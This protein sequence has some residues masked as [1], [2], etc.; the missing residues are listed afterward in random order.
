MFRMLLRKFRFLPVLMRNLGLAP[1]GSKPEDQPLLGELS[2]NLKT[3]ASLMGSSPDIIVRRFKTGLP[4]QVDAATIYIDGLADKAAINENILRPLVFEARLTGGDEELA[5]EDPVELIKGRILTL[6]DIQRIDSLGEVVDAVFAG[7]TALLVEGVCAALILSTKGWQIR[8]IDEPKTE[9]VV[10]GPRECFIENLRTNT[11]LLRRRIRDPKLTYETVRVGK[12]TKT[13][14]CVAYLKGVTN[15]RL[16][17]EIKRRLNRI[18]T[19][20]VLESGYVEQYIEDAPLSPFATIAN[21]ERPD[22]VAAK[23]LEGRAAI[24]VDGS[25]IVLTVP[26]LFV[27]SFQAPDDYYSRPYFAT[28][29]RWIRYAAFALSVLSPAVYVAL[30]AFHQEL[31]PTPLLI[32]VA[33]AREGAPFPAV[34]EA[35]G[36]GVAFEILREAGLRI[37][38][39]FGQAVSIVGALVIGEATVRA[40]LIGAPVVIV[41][42]LT[43]IC[44]FVVP[45]QQD[46]GTIIRVS[47]T[48]LAGL[49]G[50][51]GIMLGLLAILIHLASLRSFGVPYLSPIAPLKPQDLK[52]VVVRAPWWAMH[53]RPTYMGQTDPER[54]EFRLMPAPPEEGRHNEAARG[55]STGEVSD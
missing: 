24:I 18:A 32:S 19:D 51:F 43:A 39:P 37:P 31:I 21:S 23:I 33:A 49:L 17:K 50:A 26:M 10:R 52:D 34:F 53:N 41:V 55:D 40:G 27:E 45:P 5:E 46:S 22:V 25:P 44:S 1:A 54:Q 6:G 13:S 30:V 11:A 20:A 35:L 7:D 4:G 2:A 14:V 28:V 8:G 29:V 16:V 47:L 12:R 15:D 9:A 42:A 3:L 36:M 38:R 48:I